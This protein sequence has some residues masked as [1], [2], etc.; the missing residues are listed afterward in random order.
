MGVLEGTQRSSHYMTGKAISRRPTST[1]GTVVV[2]GETGTLQWDGETPTVEYVRAGAERGDQLNYEA[3][4]DTSAGAPLTRM[5]RNSPPAYAR[6]A[7][8]C[9]LE[10]NLASFWTVVAGLESVRDGGVPVRVAPPEPDPS[11]AG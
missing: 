1:Y 2:G 8:S 10:E 9:G 4:T 5:L 3:D 6:K 7:A 11:P